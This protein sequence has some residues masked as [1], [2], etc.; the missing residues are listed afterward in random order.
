M[1][2]PNLLRP[3]KA[4]IVSKLNPHDLKNLCLVNEKNNAEF[5]ENQKL[6]EY[7][8]WN[9]F[10]KLPIPNSNF[11]QYYYYH[12]TAAMALG[13]N[14]RFQLGGEDEVKRWKTIMFAVKTVVMNQ[15]ATALI[16][17]D[18]DL[19]ILGSPHFHNRDFV[20]PTWIMSNVKQVNIDINGE[21]MYIL[22]MNSELFLYEDAKLT[23]LVSG[24]VRID[25]EN[26][27]FY[28]DE[29]IYWLAPMGELFYDPYA[30]EN[31]ELKITNE[32]INEKIRQLTITVH[33]EIQKNVKYLS[34][35]YLLTTN[36]ELY[37][38][39]TG[40]LIANN[41][42]TCG[43]FVT[44]IDNKLKMYIY[45]ID[46]KFAL[47]FKSRDE[48]SVKNIT[49]DRPIIGF[50]SDYGNTYYLLTVDSDL[51]IAGTANEIFQNYING[52]LSLP[53]ENRDEVPLTT[54]NNPVLFMKN[55]LSFDVVNNNIICIVYPN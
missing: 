12:R 20:Q 47:N 8:L 31:T 26:D 44:A 39:Q 17:V 2:L 19:Y 23:F 21:F 13:P 3:L 5:C 48:N 55:V 1:N 43:E 14:A 11:S 37:V 33:G 34:G 30:V 28:G 29:A 27:I 41:V 6:W 36:N 18:N 25:G 50:K 16:T 32:S 9:E 40:Q 53:P 49:F 46:D 22:K 35:L 54:L 38:F 52:Q 15:S 4:Q 42:M 10:H 51:Y 7:L 45:W 24:I